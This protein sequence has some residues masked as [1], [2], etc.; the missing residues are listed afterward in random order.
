MLRQKGHHENGFILIEILIV[1]SLLGSITAIA[2]QSFADNSDSLDHADS[3][4]MDYLLQAF[5]LQQSPISA[6][7]NSPYDMLTPGSS[8]EQALNAFLSDALLNPSSAVYMPDI[9]RKRTQESPTTDNIIFK[10]SSSSTHVWIHCENPS[11][12]SNIQLVI[13][14][15]EKIL[16]QYSDEN[17][18]KGTWMIIGDD[19][20]LRSDYIKDL[21]YHIRSEDESVEP[22]HESDNLLAYRTITEKANADKQYHY[23]AD[24]LLQS[25]LPYP[26]PV[27]EYA[28]DE[29]WINWDPK[30]NRQVEY[31]L[32]SRGATVPPEYTMS[33]RIGKEGNSYVP[34]ASTDPYTELTSAAQEIQF[35][36]DSSENGV[37]TEIQF[38]F[39][40]ENYEPILRTYHVRTQHYDK[41]TLTLQEQITAD[42]TQEVNAGEGIYGLTLSNASEGY[43][44][45]VDLVTTEKKVDGIEFVDG[46]I[47]G[48]PHLMHYKYVGMDPGDETNEYKDQESFAGYHAG[49]ILNID[50]DSLDVANN[51]DCLLFEVVND[52]MVLSS[53]EVSNGVPSLKEREVL[54][55]FHFNVPYHINLIVKEG[56]V[57]VS[58]S[59]NLLP[60][61]DMEFAISNRIHFGIGHYMGEE[62]ALNGRKPIADDTDMTP[63]VTYNR[64]MQGPQLILLDMPNFGL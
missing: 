62:P 57:L 18:L 43:L 42:L 11:N 25:G 24:F 55:N 59:D 16:F 15:K 54:N 51:Y 49:F 3:L 28:F 52:Q 53:Y 64:G 4:Q 33:Y 19:D 38:K 21:S 14:G 56:K 6:T 2:A 37:F 29:S 58:L 40:R 9:V 8:P 13:P 36:N 5:Q 22:G 32:I 35:S 7:H 12:Q 44:W 45:C 30:Q 1:L 10:A 20:R 47:K 39:E 34:L 48:N 27:S 61:A 41:L 31:A 23:Q 63:F 46:V 50:H 60:F 26:A 17:I